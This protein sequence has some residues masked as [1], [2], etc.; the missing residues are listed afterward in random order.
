MTKNSCIYGSEIARTCPV[1]AEYPDIPLN[2]LTSAC[3]TCPLKHLY[4][5]DQMTKRAQEFMERNPPPQAYAQGW[6]GR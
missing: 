3:T 2:E 6:Q 4:L 1:R 5:Q